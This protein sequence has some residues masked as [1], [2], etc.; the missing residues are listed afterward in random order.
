M[1]KTGL[2]P[3]RGM[4]NPRLTVKRAIPRLSGFFISRGLLKR[5][6]NNQGASNEMR[7][8]RGETRAYDSCNKKGDGKTTG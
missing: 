5:S 3:K 4:T 1:V 6:A 2:P 8:E 7:K